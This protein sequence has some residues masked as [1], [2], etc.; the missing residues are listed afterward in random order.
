MST[1]FVQTNA[2][3]TLQLQYSKQSQLHRALHALSVH[4]HPLA[5]GYHAVPKLVHL[6][7]PLCLVGDS[8]SWHTYL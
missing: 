5:V 8:M 1:G 3:A 2:G 6:F 7:A 4:K